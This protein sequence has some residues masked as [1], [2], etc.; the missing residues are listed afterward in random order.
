[1]RVA[2]LCLAFLLITGFAADRASTDDRA[3]Q[4]LIRALE[5]LGGLDRLKSITSITMKGRGQEFSSAQSQGYHPEQ[6]AGAEYEETLVVH[7]SRDKLAFEH[8]TGKEDQTVRW[9]RWLYTGDE[10]V[11]GDFLVRA[12]YARRNVPTATERTRQ[13]RRIPHILIME[14]SQHPARLRM[15]REPIA[16]DGKQH[17]LILYTPPEE[18]VM[19]RLFLDAETHLLSKFDYQMDFPTLGDVVVEYTYSGYREDQNLGRVPARHAIKVAGSTSLAVDVEMSINTREAEEIFQLPEFEAGEAGER[20]QLPERLRELV[21]RPGDIV[22]AARGVNVVEV[23]GF[24]VMFIEFEDFILAVEAPAA[25]PTLTSI[26]G[27]NQPGSTSLSEAFIRKIKEKISGKPIKYLA[28]THYHSDHAGGARAFMAEG[29]TILTTPGNKRF[30]ERMAAASYK[31]VPDR[32]SRGRGRARIETFARKR[33]ITDGTRTVELINVGANPHT[34]EN[35][36]VYLPA[37]KILFQGDLFYFD[38]G[39]PFPPKNRRAIMSFF[40]G[41]LKD[42][43]LAPERIYNVHGHGFATMEHVHKA[44][45]IFRR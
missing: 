38:L 11:V 34:R 23:G 32:F 30:F 15:L 14:A 20:F 33:I 25:H 36:V 1:M 29:A 22:E 5:A 31:L 13:A 7:P 42:N 45:E 35:L 41:W 17:Y 10:R 16:Y 44:Q 37:E 26:P 28:V 2:V 3:G 12:R 21:G 43:R 19:L 39:A 18:K 9:R 6:Q 24:T 27:D 40:A 4:P 8:R